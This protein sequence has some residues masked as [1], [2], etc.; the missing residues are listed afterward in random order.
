ATA[1][2]E[3]SHVAEE[4][5]QVVVDGRLIP[6]KGLLGVGQRRQVSTTTV[7]RGLWVGQYRAHVLTGQVVP[8]LDV[9]RVTLAHQE[10]HGRIVGRAG[11]GQTVTPVFRD[12]VAAL[13][14]D[15]H[16][17]HLVVG[18]YIGPQALNDGLSLTGGASMG[19][20]DLHALA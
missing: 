14:E 6:S 4:G 16:V 1:G 18:H 3:Y 2:V 15:V 17:G 20:L 19:L 5:A 12:Q 13:V 8:V 10:C 11:I 9:F 7:T